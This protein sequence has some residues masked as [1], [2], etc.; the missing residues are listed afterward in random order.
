M[1]FSLH[2][3]KHGKKL[4]YALGFGAGL[5]LF[6]IACSSNSFMGQQKQGQRRASSV[7]VKQNNSSANII[8]SVDKLSDLSL[9][10]IAP[11]TITDFYKKALS[12]SSDESVLVHGHT[13]SNIQD[14][15]TKNESIYQNLANQYP[16][17]GDF[18][19]AI[20]V[21]SIND[22]NTEDIE[23]GYGIIAQILNAGATAKASGSDDNLPDDS[24]I[25]LQDYGEP[26]FCLKDNKEDAAKDIAIAASGSPIGDAAASKVRNANKGGCF[27]AP[28]PCADTYQTWDPILKQCVTNPNP[29]PPGTPTYPP[30]K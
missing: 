17:V 28:Y 20:K 21:S 19:N 16:T 5:H 14:Y 27:S 22:I 1:L 12:Q 10:Q 7:A 29:F 13:L 18:L 8:A 11:V 24:L 26:G 23:R 15:L 9:E 3:S 6:L 30:P 2:K 4:L 25:F